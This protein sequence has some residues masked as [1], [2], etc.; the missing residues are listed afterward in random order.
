MFGRRID[1]RVGQMVKQIRLVIADDMDQVR[2]ELRLLLPL[3]GPIEVV[4]EA[5]DGVEAVEQCEL[6]HPDVV[7]LDLEMPGMDGI[8]ACSAIKAR[9]L[10]DTVVMLSIYAT[11]E[12]VFIA[13][14]VGANA[15]VAKGSGL[16]ELMAAILRPVRNEEG[17]CPRQ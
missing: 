3:A 6:L 11:P 5:A 9:G 2:Q 13:R 4:G 12:N 10:A 16:D 17:S 14:A 15:F 7:L 8:E 1:V